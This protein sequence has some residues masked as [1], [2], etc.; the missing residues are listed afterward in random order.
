MLLAAFIGTG[1][2]FLAYAIQA[3][4]LGLRSTRYPHK[5]FHYLGGLTE[6]T[7]TLACFAAMCLWPSAFAV[8]AWGFAG[9]CLITIVTRLAAGWALPSS[10]A[11]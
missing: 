11:P 7:E 1:S 8:L 9:L 10:G 5:G 4:R 6:G 2:T 3:E